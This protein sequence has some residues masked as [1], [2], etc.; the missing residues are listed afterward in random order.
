MTAFDKSITFDDISYE[1]SILP[2][3]KSIQIQAL[4]FSNELKNTDMLKGFKIY[5]Y[6]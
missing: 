3:W 1:D 4:N 2:E 6:E 5:A